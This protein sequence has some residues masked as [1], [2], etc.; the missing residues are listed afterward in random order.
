VPAAN[1]PAL[2]ADIRRILS[3]KMRSVVVEGDSFVLPIHYS[4]ADYDAILLVNLLH[5][6]RSVNLVL[7]SARRELLDPDGHPVGTKISLA[8]DE[9]RLLIAR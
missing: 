7:K 9:I 2:L 6:P 1:L 3:P 8:A 4:R 5:E